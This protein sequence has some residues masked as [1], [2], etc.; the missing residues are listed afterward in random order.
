MR[1]EELKRLHIVKKVLAKELRQV[2]AAGKLDLSYRQTKRITK[3]IKE[4][5]DEGI[6][7][8]LRGQL[9][10]GNGSVNVKN[11]ESGVNVNI[12]LVKWF[13]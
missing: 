3:R 6:I 7:H 13:N 10:S 12:T 5:G 8:K 1:Q 4:E 11:T 2:E 9:S